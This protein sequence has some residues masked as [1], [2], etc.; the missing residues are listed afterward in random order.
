MSDPWF[1]DQLALRQITFKL[2]SGRRVAVHGFRYGE[3]YAGLLLGVPNAKYNESIIQRKLSEARSGWYEEP[4]LLPPVTRPGRHS[5]EFLPPYCCAAEISSSPLRQDEDS[6][7]LTAIWF[8]PWFFDEPLATFLERS[9]KDL[10][11]EQVAK[12][13]SY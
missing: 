4:Y 7:S 12:D 8:T 11:W 2:S 10:P 5:G 1:E 6:S 9:L 3:T 13:F